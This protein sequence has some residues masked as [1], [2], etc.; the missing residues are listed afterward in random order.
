MNTL[1]LN[2]LTAIKKAIVDTQT[3]VEEM[4]SR[5]NQQLQNITRLQYEDLRVPLQAAK[6]AGANQPTFEQIPGTLQYA[7][8]FDVNDMIYFMAQLPHAYKEGTDIYPHVHWSPESDSDPATNVLFHLAYTWVN[9]NDEITGYST[10]SSTVSTGVNQG[11]VHKLTSIGSNPAIDGTGKKI[12]S[13]LICRLQRKGAASEYPGGVFIYEFDFHY[14]ID[15]RGS[16]Q[17]TIK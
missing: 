6:V 17:E 2:N 4:N 15:T 13:M 5:L 16:R 3:Y 11:L 8:N 9:I 10:R 12:S 14:Q 1:E 7:W